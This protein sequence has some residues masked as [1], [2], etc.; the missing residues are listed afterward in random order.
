ME[1]A[2]FGLIL[3]IILQLDDSLYLAK[4]KFNKNEKRDTIKLFYL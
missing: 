1:K 2:K 4:I 3:N